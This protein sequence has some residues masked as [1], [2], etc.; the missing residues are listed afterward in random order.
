TNA[1]VPWI[2]EQ[3]FLERKL[4]ASIYVRYFSGYGQPPIAVMPVRLDPIPPQTEGAVS[5]QQNST[6]QN[7]ATVRVKG[8]EN[9]DRL[10]AKISK[11]YVSKHSGAA[12][13]AFL[14]PVIHSGNWDNELGPGVHTSDS[15]EWVLR[16]GSVN[17]ALLQFMQFGFLEALYARV[18]AHYSDLDPKTTV[19]CTRFRTFRMENSR[20]HPRAYLEARFVRKLPTR[21][22]R[23]LTDR[24]SQLCRAWSTFRILSDDNLA[25]VD[26]PWLP[27]YF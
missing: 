3:L 19:E 14:T 5:R 27:V 26:A 2:L 25:V 9:K 22:R 24:G 1:G 4:P 16:F 11:N 12:M 18:A 8:D 23:G 13:M 20:H 10:S 17:S 6:P 7:I 15:L 21:T